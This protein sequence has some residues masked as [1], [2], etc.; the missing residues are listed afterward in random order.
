MSRVF[1]ALERTE[2]LRRR[3]TSA[4]LDAPQQDHR[5][6]RPSPSDTGEFERLAGAILQARA[7]EPFTT[8]MLASPHHGEGTSTVAVGLARI[9]AGRLRVLLVDANFRSPS[10]SDLLPEAKLG[11]GLVEALAGS[12]DVETIITETGV[13]GLRLV[14]AGAVD[15]ESPRLLQTSRLAL[16]MSQLAE[17]TDVAILDAPPVMPYADAL[18]L[19]SRV[20]RVVLVTH[21]EHT[22][23]GHLER[24]KE[25]LEKS[26]AAIL[27]VVLNRTASHAP[28]W[29]QRRLNL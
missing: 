22:Q 2:G 5:S 14:A 10:L 16:L 17:T 8:M 28:S 12:A 20:E 3:K 9:L 29:L 4:V 26:G 23:R 19:A 1:Q 11:A 15:S 6:G 24:A 27:G 13:P 21:A 18:T 7:A 25:E